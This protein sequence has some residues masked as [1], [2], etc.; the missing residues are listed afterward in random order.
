MLRRSIRHM[1]L[2]LSIPAI[3]IQPKFIWRIVFLPTSLQSSRIGVIVLSSG[4]LGRRGGSARL[5][6]MAA[7]SKRL[8]TREEIK[9]M[10]LAGR[11]GGVKCHR[12]CLLRRKFLQCQ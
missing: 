9:D 5:R 8:Q 4:M 7:G 10:L 3:R 12:V 11:V 6:E 1:Y 2:V